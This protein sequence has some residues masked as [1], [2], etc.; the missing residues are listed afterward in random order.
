M[1]SHLLALWR[2]LPAPLRHA[3]HATVQAPGALTRAATEAIEK[4]M[5]ATAERRAEARARRRALRRDLPATLPVTI[6]G[7]HGA[8]H[9]LGEGARMLARGFDDAG[10]PTRAVDLSAQV[11][12]PVELRAA[13]PPPADGET[14]VVI[15]HINPPELLRW[16]RDTEG[17]PL[18][19]RRHIGYW[20]WELEDA[21][22]DW[23]PAFDLV[24]E[25]WTPSVF[26]ANAIRKIAPPRVKVTPVPYPLYLNPRPP[27]DR[28][29]FG[30]P[31][32]RVVVLMAFDLRSTAQR[33]NPPGA[34]RAFQEA[35]RAANR[36]ALLSA[37]WSGRISTPRPSKRC[38]YR[39]PTILRS[40]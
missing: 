22:Q 39:S 12:F 7:F 29:R 9:G 4:E 26:A 8:V 10:L 38:G 19:G 34:L 15:S 37:R 35:V 6:I 27:A 31:N 14:G 5:E 3:A 33:K 20:A 16:T 36:P 21:P 18:E 28:A 30:L 23:I 25:V 11:G 40:G 17:R 13:F 32:D 24:D 1:K 2:N